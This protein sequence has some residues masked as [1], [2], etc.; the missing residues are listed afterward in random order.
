Y[1]VYNRSQQQLTYASA[2]HPPAI[3]ISGDRPSIEVQKLK[4]PGMPVGMFPEAMY[5][6]ESCQIQDL[7]SLYIFSDGVYEI[8]QPDG[9]VWGLDPF[10]NLLSENNGTDDSLD[11]I[12]NFVKHLNSGEIFDDDFSLL[13]VAF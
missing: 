6:D 13:K 11:E 1:G 4:T 5:L 2:G 9:T 3:L 12:L 7:S 8:L 10:I